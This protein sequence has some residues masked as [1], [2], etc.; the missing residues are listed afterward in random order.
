MQNDISVLVEKKHKL[1][2][3]NGI[4]L[5]NYALHLR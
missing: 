5:N 4:H 1:K 2:D 3:V